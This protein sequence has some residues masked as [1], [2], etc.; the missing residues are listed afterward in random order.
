MLIS[1]LL[2][3][4]AGLKPSALVPNISRLGRIS[5][6]PGPL[7]DLGTLLG[8]A[9]MGNGYIR[10]ICLP[11]LQC[12]RVCRQLYEEAF[13]IF[14]STNIF[15]FH[16]HKDFCDFIDLLQ[17]RQRELVSKLHIN[18]KRT[19]ATDMSSNWGMSDKTMSLSTLS[20][21]KKVKQLYVDINYGEDMGWINQENDSRYRLDGCFYKTTV[22]LQVLPLQKVTISVTNGT[23]I[24][25]T[26]N[27]AWC[28]IEQLVDNLRQRLLDPDGRQRWLERKLAERR[29]A[30]ESRRLEREIRTMRKRFF[31]CSRASTD[32]DCAEWRRT[33]LADGRDR[34]VP[35]DVGPCG[36]SHACT[37]CN[38]RR[39][40]A[41]LRF[42][43]AISCARPGQCNE[44]LDSTPRVE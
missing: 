30:E 40:R 23:D 33:H 41:A 15:S 10:S 6:C 36:K 12:L 20:S 13:P 8:R 17:V 32:E 9:M 1:R 31:C 24:A 4:E 42:R 39:P 22:D 16:C 19:C 2:D 5:R 44:K 18:L 14:W 21:L 29:A 35:K 37:I 7:V 43:N 25:D 3:Y 11:Q 34:R 27:S 28:K 26:D 38:K